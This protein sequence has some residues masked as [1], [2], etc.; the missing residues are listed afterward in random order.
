MLVEG[1]SVRATSRMAGVAI[2]TVQKLLLDVGAARQP[3]TRTSTCG[4]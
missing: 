1:S 3:H 4:T 2:N